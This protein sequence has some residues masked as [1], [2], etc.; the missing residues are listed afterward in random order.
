MQIECPSC[1]TVNKIEFGENIVCCECK[2]SFAGHSYKK[3]KK[4]LISATTAL[5]IGAFGT[6]KADQIFFE[7]QRYPINVEY[8]LIDSCIN[9]SRVPMNSYRQTEKTQVCVCALEKTMEV[10]SYEE[11]KKSESEFLTRFRSSLASCN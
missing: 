4:P 1:A 6:Y 3:F 8:E 7:D 9:S 5:F 2:E 11:L 10:I